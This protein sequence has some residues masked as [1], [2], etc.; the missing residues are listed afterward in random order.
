MKARVVVIRWSRW[1]GKEP[2]DESS[3]LISWENGRKTSFL[4]FSFS[5]VSIQLLG[6][7]YPGLASLISIEIDL[8][9]P[10]P[11][12]FRWMEGNKRSKLLHECYTTE[13]LSLSLKYF[14]Q[15]ILVTSHSSPKAWLTKRAI[16]KRLG[17]R[18]GPARFELNA[19]LIIT[20]LLPTTHLVGLLAFN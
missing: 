12:A 9:N 5:I 19:I 11:V 3:G 18:P 20:L 16:K 15:P 13:I 1:I 17:W 8:S 10:R 4:F 7:F 2:G 14:N 6:L